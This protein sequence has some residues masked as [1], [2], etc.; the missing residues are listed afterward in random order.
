MNVRREKRVVGAAVTL[1]MGLLSFQDLSFASDQSRAKELIQQTCVQCHRFEGTA[2]SRF[3]LR[4]PDLIWAGSKYQ[5]SWL[6][7]WLTGKEGP[8]YAKG[9]RWDLTDVPAKHPMVTE[10]EANAIA[11]YF[12]EHNKDPRVTVGAFDFSKV[13]KFDVTFGGIAYKAHACL[14]CHTIEENGKLIGGHRA[15][16]CRMPV[17]GTTWIGCTG[18]GRIRRTSSFIPGNFWLMRPIRSCER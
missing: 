11:D 8:L 13:T 16:L 4:A 9:Y 18:L 3:N 1:I 15:R 14:G 17:S 2:D 12:A 7:R 5:R 10:S 6:I